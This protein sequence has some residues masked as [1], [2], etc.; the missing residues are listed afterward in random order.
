MRKISQQINKNKGWLV[1]IL[2]ASALLWT[3]CTKSPKW[4][5]DEVEVSYI[6]ISSD[7]VNLRDTAGKSIVIK[8]GF[9]DGNGDLATDESDAKE[10]L[11]IRD[12]RDTNTAKDYTFA[13]PIPYVEPKLRPDNGSISGQVEI[14]LDKSY[15]FITDPAKIL[16]G[17]DTVRYLIYIKDDAG[18]RSRTVTTDPIY[19]FL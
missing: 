13:H 2:L 3:A 6:G 14:E 9:T 4:Y 7:S 5:P 15:F 17:R 16:L 10:Y 1:G 12:S 11:F 18:N 19:I 8:L